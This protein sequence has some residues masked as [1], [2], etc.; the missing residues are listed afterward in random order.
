[1]TYLR[2][3][4]KSVLVHSLAS[5][6]RILRGMSYIEKEERLISHQHV[7][8]S[9]SNVSDNSLLHPKSCLTMPHRLISFSSEAVKLPCVREVKG[10]SKM[11][12]KWIILV[13][14]QLLNQVRTMEILNLFIVF[15]G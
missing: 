12:F 3:I 11:Q 9:S 15:V 8:S 13:Q 10:L 14:V 7:I 6:D 1:M 5:F 2:V 4:N